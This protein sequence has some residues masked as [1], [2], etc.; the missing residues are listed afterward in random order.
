MKKDVVLSSIIIII[1]LILAVISFFALKSLNK[2]YPQGDKEYCLD[3]Q[4]N[5]DVCMNLYA[6][7]CGYYS[8]KTLL[9]TFPNSCVACINE[10]VNYYILGECK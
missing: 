5:A 7:V 2:I 6:P 9:S 3:E 8:N 1:F 10:D 4:R